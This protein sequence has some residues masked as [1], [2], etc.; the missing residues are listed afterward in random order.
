MTLRS[1]R[2]FL[3]SLLLLMMATM[4][5]AAEP[6]STQR[7][8]SV[9][10]SITFNGTEHLHRWSKDGQHEYTPK[11]QEDLANWSDMIT[12][13]VYAKI[14]DGEALA[15]AANSTLEKYKKHNAKVLRTDSIPRTAEKEAEHLIVALFP[16]PRF[17]ESVFARFRISRGV[18]QSLVYS[19]RTH[20]EKAG[21]ATSEWLKEN[22][23]TIEKKLMGWK[24]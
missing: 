2:L 11:G 14:T 21:P 6:D 8:T 13:N 15:S 9:P 3:P 20:G 5:V 16:R 17:I 1:R 18:G 10:A 7:P 23:P 19:H 22:G 12:L 4:L 24:D